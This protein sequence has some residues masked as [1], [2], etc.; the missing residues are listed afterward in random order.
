MH[1]IVPKLLYVMM[2][3]LK[4]EK[5][6]KDPGTITSSRGK[7]GVITNDEVI[8]HDPHSEFLQFDETFLTIVNLGGT[9]P[10]AT[11]HPFPASLV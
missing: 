1:P 9:C 6:S 2:Y 3:L 8:L 4:A 10:S 11:R 7:F 5:D